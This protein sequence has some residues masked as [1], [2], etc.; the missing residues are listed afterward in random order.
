MSLSAVIFSISLRNIFP[1]TF[2]LVFFVINSLQCSS[3]DIS[4]PKKEEYSEGTPYGLGSNIINSIF[5]KN[6]IIYAATNEGLSISYDEGKNF[7]NRSIEDGL[8]VMDIKDIF[9]LDKK[10]FIATWGGGLAISN[11]EGKS[12]SKT[13][14][15]T[16][17]IASNQCNSVFAANNGQEIY[18]AT[19]SGLSV[20]LDGGKTF[21]TKTKA[22]G[23]GSDAVRKVIV[24]SNIIYAATHDGLSI[25]TDDGKSFQNKTTENGLGINMTFDIFVDGGDIYAATM[26]GLG[27][28]ADGGN[29]FNNVNSYS[30]LG[31][32]Y[33]FGIDVKSDTIYAATSG[34]DGG[35]VSISTDNGETFSNKTSEEGL[36]SDYVNDVFVLNETIY[37]A[38]TGGLSISKDN[39]NCF[40]NKT[41]GTG[42]EEEDEG[43]SC[44]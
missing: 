30:G 29:T 21:S 26:G 8:P 20:S 31:S 2:F 14:D 9:I 27:I 11:D 6:K 34:P 16:N 1:F 4:E 38:T 41:S 22:D 42:G 24:D 25:S 13:L 36:G 10:V 43:D 33:I 18:A 23:L 39:G 15:V 44:E 12:I 17:G 19:D 5:V 28:S 35:G 37:A 7:I 32:N 3:S 40:I